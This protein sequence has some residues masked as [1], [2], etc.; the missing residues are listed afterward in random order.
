MNNKKNCWGNSDEGL[1]KLKWAIYIPSYII[2]GPFKNQ[3]LLEY[4]EE[5]VSHHGH[6]YTV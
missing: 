5:K 6:E 4:M 1:W 2:L 3:A